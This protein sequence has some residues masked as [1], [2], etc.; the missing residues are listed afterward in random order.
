MS[1]RPDRPVSAHTACCRVPSPAVRLD[2]DPAASRSLSYSAGTSSMTQVSGLVVLRQQP[3]SAWVHG[4]SALP[5]T[6]CRGAGNHAIV[7]E[8]QGGVGSEEI[9]NR[10]AILLQHL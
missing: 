5:P 2:F 7:R 8:V 9:E 4:S 6:G 1:D 3:T 10:A